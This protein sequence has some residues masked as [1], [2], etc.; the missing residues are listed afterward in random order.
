MK[1]LLATETQNNHIRIAQASEVFRTAYASS[2]ASNISLS[3][4]DI[5]DLVKEKCVRPSLLIQKYKLC[6][7]GLGILSRVLPSSCS[8][9]LSK[10][11]DETVRTHL[12]NAIREGGE[13]LDDDIKQTLK[14]HRSVKLVSDEA[15]HSDN[16][17]QS[18]NGSVFSILKS[19]T[20]ILSF[21]IYNFLHLS[22]NV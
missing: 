13:S 15:K 5:D 2:S 6:G 8:N 22:K 18:D 10:V 17:S 19:P 11:V 12:N 14:Y 3:V 20:A 9:E 16:N 1:R 4:S 21:G 7:M